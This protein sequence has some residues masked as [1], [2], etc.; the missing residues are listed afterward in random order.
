MLHQME[1]DALYEMG[2]RK[3]ADRDWGDAI[4]ALEQFVLRFPGD[5]RHQ[6]VRFKLATAR[7][8]KKDYITAASEF[9]RLTS[10][11]PS[12]RFAAESRFKTCQS[13]YR[14][15]PKPQLDQEYTRAA[16]DHCGAL[17]AFYPSSEFAPQAQELMDDLMEKLAQKEYMNGEYYY[18]RRALD[19]SLL[20][21]ENL[22][23]DYPNSAY[24]P[25]ALL[26][27]VQVYHRLG[28]EEEMQEALERLLREYP[29]TEEAKQAE[30]LASAGDS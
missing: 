23:R 4:R 1:A 29:G 6:E 30:A 7:F 25:K 17:V 22:L 19:S 20:Y 10:D 11:Y 9:I 3:L 14:L 21:F 8:E 24:V 28:Y 5:P 15:S 2:E 13:Y 16:L 12:G 27:I 26:R 18:K